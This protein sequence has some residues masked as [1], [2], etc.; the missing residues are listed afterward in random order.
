MNR[1][2]FEPHVDDA[3]L[4]LHGH[5]QNWLKAG[6]KVL[7]V[8]VTCDKKRAAEAG[9]YAAASGHVSL[10]LNQSEGEITL[11]TLD[12]ESEFPLDD[13]SGETQVY[14]PLGLQHPDHV[15]VREQVSALYPN[16]LLYMDNPYYTKPKNAEELAIKTHG[17]TVVSMFVPS[18]RD[19]GAEKYWKCFK[20]QSLFFH[21]NPPERWA[22]IPEIILS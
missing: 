13:W 4:S 3:F 18:M 9:S 1:I 14:C 12:L 11:K 15:S 21:Y 19:K 20:S 5:I 7:V 2:V 10:T 22:R 8:S 6:D 16:R 17:A